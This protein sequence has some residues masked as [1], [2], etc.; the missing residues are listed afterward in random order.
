MS[1]LEEIEVLKRKK[2]SDFVCCFEAANGLLQR[3]KS[4]RKQTH[5]YLIH[6]KKKKSRKIWCNKIGTLLGT[7]RIDISCFYA[8]FSVS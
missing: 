4:E 3:R 2:E 8:T 7:K 5:K 6:S 1:A